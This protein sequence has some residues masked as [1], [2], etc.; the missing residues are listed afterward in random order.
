MAEPQEETSSQGNQESSASSLLPS[1]RR[2]CPV[3]PEPKVTVLESSQ[4]LGVFRL[5]PTTLGEQKTMPGVAGQRGRLKTTG[6]FSLEI[7]VARGWAAMPGPRL[8]HACVSQFS[9][10]TP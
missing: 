7:E 5:P 9:P 4:N 8:P 1:K 3:A 2:G 10:N 6:R